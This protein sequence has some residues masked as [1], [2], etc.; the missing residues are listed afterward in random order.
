MIGTGAE[1]FIGGIGTRIIRTTAEDEEREH[2]QQASETHGTAGWVEQ[3]KSL[4]KLG[5]TA[6]DDKPHM[7]SVN[8]G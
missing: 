2:K 3:R 5:G 8:L 1:P 7:L 4:T 6:E